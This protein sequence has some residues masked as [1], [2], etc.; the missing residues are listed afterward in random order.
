MLHSLIVLPDQTVKSIVDAI[1]SAK[2]SVRVKM[3]LFSA[4]GS[5][6]GRDC[7]EEA[8][9]RRARHAQSCA[10]ERGNPTMT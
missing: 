5:A 10:A 1:H 3:F 9:S 6:Q 8:G 7:R 4:S 2:K